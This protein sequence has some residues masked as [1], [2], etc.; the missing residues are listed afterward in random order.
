MQPALFDELSL[1]GARRTAW[2]FGAGASV[3]APYSVPT[4][5]RLLEAFA[6]MG[7]FGRTPA[8]RAAFRRLQKRVQAHVERVLPGRPFTS[9]ATALEEVF[10]WYELVRDGRELPTMPGERAAAV[11]ALTDLV[12]ALGAVTTVRGANTAKK[13]KPFPE[14]P[15]EPKA[16]APYAELIERL[17]TR[18]ERDGQAHA[19]AASAHRLVTMNYD[20]S[21]DRCLL[22]LNGQGVHLDYGVPVAGLGAAQRPD[23][24]PD[25]ATF[26]LLR[27]HGSLNWLR[28]PEAAC[29]VLHYSGD[30]HADADGRLCPAC[31]RGRLLPVLVYPSFTRTYD[32][33]V[34]DAVWTR[35]RLELTSADRWVFVG[36]SM[37]RADVHFRALLRGCLARRRAAGLSTDVVVVGRGPVALDDPNHELTLAATEYWGLFGAS[38]RLWRATENGFT[39]LPARICP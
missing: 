15:R 30:L 38:L 16:K 1:A 31:G 20:I 39:D 13:F 10:S 17:L 32:D 35:T 8:E 11:E 27:V 24:A 18:G 4:Q 22:H 9:R 21:L 7:P 29:G 19:F 3:C 6:A 23:G 14:T 2:I 36:Y 33:P 28:C 34:I 26:L 37:P 25:E 5:A 12:E